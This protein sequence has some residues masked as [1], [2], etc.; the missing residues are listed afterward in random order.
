MDSL[1]LEPRSLGRWRVDLIEA[2]RGAPI[3]F[4]HGSG[5][6]AF[7]WKSVLERLAGDLD[8]LGEL[9]RS[10]DSPV[11]LVGHSYGALLAVRFA[12]GRARGL[13]SLCLTEP[14]AFGLLRDGTGDHRRDARIGTVLQDF[15]SLSSRF[16]AEV[17]CAYEDRTSTTDGITCTTAVPASCW[18]A[19]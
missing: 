1:R 12:M 10:L 15:L 2:G 16:H 17:T 18:A 5:D 19:V 7:A 13:R 11:H 3:V 8:L 6:G 14:I 4:L 9:V